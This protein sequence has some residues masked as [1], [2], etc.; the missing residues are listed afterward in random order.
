MTRTRL[1][2]WFRIGIRWDSGVSGGEYIAFEAMRKRESSRKNTDIEPKDSVDGIE[3][4][5]PC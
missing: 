1:Q 4:R 5:E 2:D 3:G